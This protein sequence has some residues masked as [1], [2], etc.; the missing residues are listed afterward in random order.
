MPNAPFV[1]LAKAA[2]ACTG[3]S[4]SL[5]AGWSFFWNR[6]TPRTNAIF[7]HIEQLRVQRALGIVIFPLAFCH[8][9]PTEPEIQAQGDRSSSSSARVSSKSRD[10][11]KAQKIRGRTRGGGPWYQIQR[12]R[13][14]AEQLRVA[15]AGD[16]DGSSRQGTRPRR[17]RFPGCSRLVARKLKRGNGKYRLRSPGQHR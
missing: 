10:P 6:G 12:E 15:I 7:F 3:L 9:D 13:W 8:G 1:D 11:K 5:T 14:C 16:R 17:V 4:V 2:A